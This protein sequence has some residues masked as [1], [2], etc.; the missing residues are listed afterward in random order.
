[1]HILIVNNTKIPAVDYGGVER[2]IWWLGKFLKRSGHKISYLVAPGSECS[3]AQVLK[4]DP[5][6]ALNQQIPDS[7]DFVHMCFQTKEQLK[8]PYLMM[9]QYNEH[10]SDEFDINTVFVSQN[11][12]ARNKSQCY[13]HNGIDPDEYGPVEFSNPRKYLLFVGW[14]SRP[15]KNLRDCLHIAR[16]TGNVLAVLGGRDKWFKRRPWVKYQGFIGGEAKNE[17]FRQ[18]KALLFP[19]RWE[20]PCAVALF[21]SFYFGCPVFGSRYGCLPELINDELGFLSN[22]RFELAEAVKNRLPQYNPKRIHEY[23]CEHLSAKRMTENY[24]RL[25]EKVLSGKTLNEK[26][27]VNGGNFSR[28]NLLPIY[29]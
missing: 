1:M 26:R 6:V 11:Q 23:A 8:K 24:L 4:Y 27:P 20:E 25:Y 10:F 14:A 18:G 13:V 29:P 16:K 3:F 7:V 21:E 15:E 5:S 19:V 2:V 9:H 28:D 17:F 12:A 22:S